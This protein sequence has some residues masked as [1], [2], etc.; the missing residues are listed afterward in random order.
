M[1]AQAGSAH[2]ATRTK[3]ISLPLS[4]VTILT[5]TVAATLLAHELLVKRTNV[6]RFLFGMKRLAEKQP[7]SKRLL[8]EG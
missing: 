2:E 5:L 8:A 4:L 1:Q 3:E 6:M 7:A